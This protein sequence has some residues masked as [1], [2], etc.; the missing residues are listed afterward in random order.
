MRL[1]LA[2]VGGAV[3]LAGSVAFVMAAAL[4]LGG[5]AVGTGVQGIGGLVFDLGLVLVATAAGILAITGEGPL[6]RMSTR[7]GLVILGL[8]VLAILASA[9][10]IRLGADLLTAALLQVAIGLPLA[11]LG[12]IILGASLARRTGPERLVGR[13]ALLG[14]GLVPVLVVLANLG[15]TGLQFSALGAPVAALAI[16]MLLAALGGI[17]YLALS[18]RW[19]WR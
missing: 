19:S 6:A 5:V 7:V 10:A 15:E 8:G 14:L 11:V 18:D 3:M 17:G 12:M 2:R 13:S 1:T 9:V 4:V 16:G